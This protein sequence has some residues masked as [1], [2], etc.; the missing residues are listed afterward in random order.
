[1]WG[2]LIRTIWAE[3]LLCRASD[4]VKALRATGNFHNQVSKVPENIFV[5]GTRDENLKRE[6]F[7][8]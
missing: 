1:M 4:K 2:V 5:N 7:L 8:H 6:N 3:E